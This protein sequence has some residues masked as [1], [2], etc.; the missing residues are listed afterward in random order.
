MLSGKTNTETPN[1]PGTTDR[2]DTTNKI[3]N[4]IFIEEKLTLTTEW[5]KTFVKSSQ[6]EHK[7]V[8][9]HNRYGIT[10]GRCGAFRSGKGAG[11]RFVR[12]DTGGKRVPHYS[13]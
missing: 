11:F 3:K 8:T 10:L 12:P 7:K 13:F 2:P 1:I 5:D 4:T 9:F 6:V